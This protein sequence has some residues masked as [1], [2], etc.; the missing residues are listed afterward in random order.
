[1]VQEQLQ[2]TNS[3][4]WRLK[5]VMMSIAIFFILSALGIYVSSIGFF[6]GLQNINSA[7]VI[8]NYSTE[9]IEALDTSNT[10][11]ERLRTRPNLKDIYFSF[12]ENQKILK[13]S[14][15]KSIK[16]ARKNAE[17]SQLLQ[18]CLDSVYQYEES[19]NH[20]FETYKR[21][22]N[23]E[24]LNS[25]LLIV[26]QYAIDAKEFLRKSQIKL[27][28]DSDE[29]FTSIYTNRFRPLLVAVT[30]SGFFFIFVITFG[31]STAKKITVSV[32]NLKEATDRVR[33]G[34]L[35]YQAVV[36]DNDEFGMLTDTFNKM[37]S[38]LNLSL[39]R[40]RT[41]QKITAQFSEA[42][43]AEQVVDITIKEGLKAMNADSGMVVIPVNEGQQVEIAGGVGLHPDSREKWGRYSVN[44]HTPAAEAI[45][46]RKP[47]FIETKNEAI[48]EFPVLD[49]DIRK[50]NLSAIATAPL[51]IGETCL[52]CVNFIFQQERKFSEEDK[53]FIQA[54]TGQCAQALYRTKLY[55]DARKAIQVRDEFL[56]IASHE[57]KTPLTPLKLQLQ[58]LARQIKQEPEAL[59][60][61]KLDKIMKNSDKQLNRLSKLIDDLL[62]VSRISAGKLK[63]DLEEVNLQDILKEILVQ[64]GHQ[65]QSNHEKVELEADVP[66]YCK[67]DPLRIEQVLINLLTNAVK[68]APMK[69]IRISL[70]KEKNCAKI[71]VKDQGPGISKEHHERIF[72]RF[73]RVKATDNIGG[74]GL[75]LYISRQII[76]AHNGKIYVESEPGA[77]SNFIIELPLSQNV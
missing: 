36:L 9:S 30:L 3:I 19:V 17:I 64:Y 2:T 70:V 48:Q 57:L 11:L 50:N 63:L 27:R 40:I 12:Q 43:T 6:E 60:D 52:G 39:D 77:G 7:N 28:H 14:I 24:E 23:L 15:N 75:G 73:E 34:N 42:L 35:S 71:C 20:L 53:K 46:S 1:M 47:A 33:E 62:D 5:V 4:T 58:L 37:V 41:L 21:K 26:N 61:V 69:T 54:I 8:L 32:Q 66:V 10:N 76:E 45:R 49:E 31:F 59:T 65:L 38:T 25:E 67:V 72:R 55:D 74:L 44:S 56:S 22:A 51:L 13:A 16:E 68:Y 29:L 18:K